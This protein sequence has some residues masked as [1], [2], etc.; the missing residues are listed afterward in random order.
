MDFFDM[1]G[2]KNVNF[3][4]DDALPRHYVG[5]TLN[6]RYRLVRLDAQWSYAEA[7]RELTEQCMVRLCA[8]AD[9][10]RRRMLSFG[11]GKLDEIAGQVQREGHYDP[12]GDRVLLFEAEF[13]FAQ[14][15]FMELARQADV[16]RARLYGINA[17]LASIAS[18]RAQLYRQTDTEMRAGQLS[19]EVP[20]SE[21]SRLWTL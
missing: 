19:N 5:A 16:F 13:N 14:L 15:S 12:A 17:S 11:Q 18:R 10:Y 2:L 9:V 3:S 8:R 1:H 20:F 21:S 7:E 6:S 4:D